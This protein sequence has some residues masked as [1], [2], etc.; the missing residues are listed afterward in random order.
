MLKRSVND[1][2]VR[3][4][5]EEYFIQKESLSTL[6]ERYSLTTSLLRKVIHGL[7]GYK[8]IEDNIP[9]DIKES[10]LP[11]NRSPFMTRYDTR[12]MRGL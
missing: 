9:S 11:G 7:N 6:A 5:R 12:K 3:K 8:S 4:I 10:R 1:E 2:T